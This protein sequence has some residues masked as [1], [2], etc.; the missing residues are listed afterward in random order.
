MD[1]DLESNPLQPPKVI[2]PPRDR[3][4]CCSKT[5]VKTLDYGMK[6]SI[7]ITSMVFSISMI[8]Y[9]SVFDKNDCNDPLLPLYTG[10]ITGC[11]GL[12]IDKPKL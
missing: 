11:I 7:M 10:I 8:V 3:L 12:F 9:D 1:H 5:N 2:D 4:Q 6:M